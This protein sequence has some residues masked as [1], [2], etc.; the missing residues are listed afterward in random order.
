ML[1][2][3]LDENRIPIMM[4]GAR[5]HPKRFDALVVSAAVVIVAGMQRL[6]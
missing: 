3:A 5:A 1:A 2:E 4:Q 6:M